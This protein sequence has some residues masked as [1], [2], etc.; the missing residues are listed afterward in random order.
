MF[1]HWV[2]F[3]KFFV[4]SIIFTCKNAELKKIVNRKGKIVLIVKSLIV[5][6]FANETIQNK[7]KKK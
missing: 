5:F 2:S 4:N 6:K 3:Q 7:T 1:V